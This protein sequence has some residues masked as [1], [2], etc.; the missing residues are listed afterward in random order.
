MEDKM[1]DEEPKMSP[2]ELRVYLL[3]KMYGPEARDR[4]Y[5][6]HDVLLVNIKANLPELKQVLSDV[7]ERGEDY[8][9]RFYHGSFKVYWIQGQ[10][11]KILDL[12]EKISPHEGEAKKEFH[13][14]FE[15]IIKDGCSGKQWEHAHNLRWFETTSPFL[16]AYFHA[17][18]FLEMAVKYGEELSEAPNVMPSGWAALT[19]L[20]QI[21]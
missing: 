5:K 13:Q 1:A 12:L 11:R 14:D 3:D 6:K 10:T 20:Y 8:I 16:V 19:E 21:R 18:Y 2:E 4:R 17:K 7:I 9:Y 15:Q